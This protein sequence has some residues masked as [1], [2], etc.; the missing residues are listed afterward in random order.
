MTIRIEFTGDDAQAIAHEILTVGFLI[1][2]SIGAQAPAAA[3]AKP[4]ETVEAETIDPPKKPGRKAAAA[5]KTEIVEEVKNAEPDGAGDRV[6]EDDAPG[7]EAA[8]DP[9]P[10]DAAPAKVDEVAK[11]ETPPMTIDELRKYT[12]GYLTFAHKKLDDQKAEFADLLGKF[13]VTK[14][15][16]LPEDKIAEM[17]A[18]VDERKAK[19][20]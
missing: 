9:A 19:L 10:E 16:D 5:K 12:V 4:V 14:I 7:E 17:K 15:G 18:L 6:A 1:R 2:G 20:A 3:P 13:N 8:G 11:A